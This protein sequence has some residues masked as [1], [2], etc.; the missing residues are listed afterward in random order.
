VNKQNARESRR[1]SLVDN[2]WKIPW[3]ETWMKTLF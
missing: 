1:F 3:T 2:K